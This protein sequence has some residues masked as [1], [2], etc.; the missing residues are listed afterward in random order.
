MSIKISELTE[1]TM[2][3]DESEI[4][5]VSDNETK[6]FKYETLKKQLQIELKLPKEIVV[7]SQL[8]AG[9]SNPVQNRTLY[10]YFQQIVSSVTAAATYA[11]NAE[12]RANLASES[13][14][15]ARESAKRAEEASTEIGKE[16]EE[17]KEKIDNVVRLENGVLYI[18]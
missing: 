17:L 8:D 18:P 7:D 4:P 15:H 6:K 5:V 12:E 16:V 11:A 1:C 14:V 10:T 3:K 9:S 2:L 13:A